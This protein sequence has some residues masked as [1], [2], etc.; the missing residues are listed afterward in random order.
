M[1]KRTRYFLTG[2]AAIL[3]TGVCTGLIAYYGG[4]FQALVASTGPM[5]LAYV[6]A[7]AA[8]VAYADVRSIMDSDLR[9]R[10]KQAVPMGEEGQQEFFE[11]TGIKLDQDVDYVVAAMTPGGSFEKSGILVARG[12][13]DTVKLEGLA[14]EHGAEV[15]EYRGKRLLVLNHAAYHADTDPSAEPRP[16][17]TQKT[18]ALAFLETG[19]VGIG[20]LDGVKRAIDAQLSAQS[21]TSNS[22]MMELVRDIVQANNAWA[23]G[24]FDVIASH[25]KLPEQIS[26]QMPPVK[27]FAAAGHINGGVSAQ[28]RAEANDDQAGE[29]LRGVINGVISLARLQGQKDPKLSPLVDSLQLSGSGKS[30]QVSFTIPAEIFELMAPKVNAVH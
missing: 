26:R 15:Q 22:E 4:G 10:F 28:L 27:W 8:V 21:I 25:T 18:G 3:A 6:P 12:R 11:H 5:E 19:L 23:V 7:D 9:Q 30:V 29:N 16:V 20:D 24:R 1:T 2:S 17:T 13:F 14:R